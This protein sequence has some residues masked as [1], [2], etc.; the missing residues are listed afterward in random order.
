MY[1]KTFA[2]LFTKRNFKQY[3]EVEVDMSVHSQLESLKFTRMRSMCKTVPHKWRNMIE[4]T[5]A[6]GQVQGVTI[7][8]KGKNSRMVVIGEGTEANYL[9]LINTVHVTEC[10]E[11]ESLCAGCI[12]VGSC[13]VKVSSVSPSSITR[14]LLA[15][16]EAIWILICPSSSGVF[17]D[18]GGHTRAA[19]MSTP[20]A[21]VDEDAMPIS[22]SLTLFPCTRTRLC[23]LCCDRK[24]S[25]FP[26]LDDLR[27]RQ[28]RLCNVLPLTP[29]LPIR[30]LH[31]Q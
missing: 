12:A 31:S 1:E 6:F 17:G 3:N 28:S 2:C 24:P 23:L 8:W 22:G 30:P 10:L 29:M 25:I 4:E 7:T 14:M 26:S 19:C 27:S 15:S 16:G 9:R 21:V 13:C 5:S 20:L 11:W 18:G